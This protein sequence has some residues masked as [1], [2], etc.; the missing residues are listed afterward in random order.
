MKFINY[1]LRLLLRKNKSNF[2]LVTVI[3][4]IMTV[5]GS[6]AQTKKAPPKNNSPQLK[7]GLYKNCTAKRITDGDTVVAICQQ[8]ELK[9][10]VFGIDAPETG[11]KYWGDKATKYL[12]GLIQNKKFDVEIKDI[13]RY[14]RY[15]A[16]IILGTGPNSDLGL[17]MVKSGNAVVYYRYNKESAYAAAEQLAK[18]K[19]IGI[20][21]T[22]GAQQN[23][24]KWRKL[25]KNR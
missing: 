6:F 12:V 24:E 14:G 7:V 3:V 15:V 18:R 5:I 11:Q 9:I 1:F 25:N 4:A 10:R 17:E 23:P 22:P 21:S 20:W 16:K 13:D 2:I 19:K 8:K